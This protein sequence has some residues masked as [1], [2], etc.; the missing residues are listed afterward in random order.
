MPPAAVELSADAADELARRLGWQRAPQAGPRW[1]GATSTVTRWG[2]VYAVKVPHLDQ[3]SVQSCL[4]HARVSDA[5]RRLGVN[6]PVIVAVED[7]RPLVPVP[8]IVS[9][10]FPGLALSAGDSKAAIWKVVGGQLALLHRASAQDAPTGL[11]TFTQ[12]D[13]VDPAALTDRLVTAGRLGDEMADRVKELRDRLVP[14]VLPDDHPVLCHGDVHAENVIASSGR[15]VG[16]VDF[17][18][19]GWLDAAWDFAALPLAA[20]PAAVGGYSTA[21]G[22]RESLVERIAWCRLQSA[23]HRLSAAEHPAEDVRRAIDGARW[24]LGVS[25]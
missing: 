12:R 13:D 5:A 6:A 19:A 15:Y 20:V 8:V 7:L 25:R 9:T 24:L 22:E 16:L 17:A 23:L 3:N 2:D 11:R 21:G 4:T 10:F 14:Q 1:T 18:G